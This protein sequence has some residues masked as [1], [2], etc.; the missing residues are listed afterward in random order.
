MYLHSVLF[1][2]RWW[3]LQDDQAVC[4]I[5]LHNAMVTWWTVSFVCYKFAST[6][7]VQLP[8]LV[9]RIGYTIG[10]CITM[11]R[12]LMSVASA[13]PLT[14][15]ILSPITAKLSFHWMMLMTH[16]MCMIIPMMINTVNFT[17]SSHYGTW[18]VVTARCN[19]STHTRSEYYVFSLSLFPPLT[20]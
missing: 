20:F 8:P 1:F 18:A 7:S 19:R 2:H 16:Q 9:V 13:E 4:R 10:A 12:E 17:A 11:S 15:L 14:P 5:N 3:I 6:W